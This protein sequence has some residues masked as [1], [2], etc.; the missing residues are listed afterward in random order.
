MLVRT[1]AIRL[2]VEIRSTETTAD[3]IV[4]KGVA[5]AMPC[6]VE[7]TGGELLALA[8]FTLRPAVLKLILA[9]LF[10]RKPG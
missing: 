7:M 2:A 8:G 4:F 6:S 1:P 5:N 9:G 10:R 3:R